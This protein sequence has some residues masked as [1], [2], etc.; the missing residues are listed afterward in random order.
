M[1]AS[2]SSKGQSV[3]TVLR[4]M[5]ESAGLTMR[6]VGAIVGISHVAISQFENRKLELPE[7]RIEQMVRAYGLTI[8]DFNKLMGRTP[9]GNPKDDCHAMIDRMGDEQLAALAAV[10]KQLLRAQNE[11]AVF[12][13]EEVRSIRAV[14]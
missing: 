7:Y 2:S 10:M 14:N 4:R 11:S 1:K 12:G 6:Q 9:I 5:R 8:E 13:S 3:S